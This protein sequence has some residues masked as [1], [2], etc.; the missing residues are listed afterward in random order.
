VPEP[1][2]DIRWPA[3]PGGLP[4]FERR[5]LRELRL[6]AR[7]NTLAARRALMGQRVRA[8]RLVAAADLRGWADSMR[9]L[10]R[11]FATAW[12][13]R[14]KP[15]RLADNLRLMKLAEEE[16]HRESVRRGI[17]EPQH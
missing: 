4:E 9:E 17:I 8:G 5:A 13:A 1:V 3:V 10:A 2:A 15:S 12:L 6:A 11:N 14:N 7:M 16:C